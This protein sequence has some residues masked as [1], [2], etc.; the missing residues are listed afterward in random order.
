DDGVHPGYELPE[1]HRLSQFVLEGRESGGRIVRETVSGEFP[2]A[3]GTT[4][5]VIVGL[6]AE[7]GEVRVAGADLL[8]Q[9]WDAAARTLTLRL[10]SEGDWQVN[11]V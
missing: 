5:L 7:P 2:L 10:R 9:T 1:R 6:S 11:F 3:Y 4:R 8:D